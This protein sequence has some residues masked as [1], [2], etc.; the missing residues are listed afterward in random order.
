MFHVLI[1][2]PFFLFSSAPLTE[3]QIDVLANSID[4]EDGLVD[5]E[6]FLNSFVVVDVV[7]PSPS[8]EQ[9]NVTASLK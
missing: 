1:S 7:M 3:G 6:E 4:V 5:Y 9:A 8:L 2:V